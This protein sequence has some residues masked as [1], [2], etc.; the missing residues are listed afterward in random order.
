MKVKMFVCEK[1]VE[2]ELKLDTK[3]L[4]CD[5]VKADGHSDRINEDPEKHYLL[6]I[7]EL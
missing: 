1:D 6:A 3:A 2:V 5:G 7:F 4:G